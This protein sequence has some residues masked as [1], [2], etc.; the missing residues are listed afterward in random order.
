MFD[1]WFIRLL[2]RTISSTTHHNNS[3]CYI[4][5]RKCSSKKLFL[6]DV[7]TKNLRILARN[8]QVRHATPKIPILH[9]NFG[10]ITN[11]EVPDF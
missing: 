4:S 8:F 10:Y 2:C 7:F 1:K 5:Q 6:V 3:N 9:Q 11:F